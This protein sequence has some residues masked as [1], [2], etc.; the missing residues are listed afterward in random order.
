M[1]FHLSDVGLQTV[2]SVQPQNEP[3][4]E[5]AEPMAERNLP[6]LKKQRRVICFSQDRYKY[7]YLV[8]K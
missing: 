4:L 3:Q 1:K 2:H 5:G 7:L 6:V 8:F